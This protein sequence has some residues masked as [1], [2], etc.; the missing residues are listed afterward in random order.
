MPVVMM[1]SWAGVT[2]DQY[3]KVRQLANF[4]GDTPR[5]GLLHLAAFTDSGL[6]VTDLWERPEDFEA[7]VQARLMPAVHQAG[8]Q[9]QPVVEI[10]AAHNV[11]TPGYTRL[12]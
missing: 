4:E 2:R 7:F 5:G 3:E 9:T 6:R 8:I 12:A 11:F 10:A 1:M